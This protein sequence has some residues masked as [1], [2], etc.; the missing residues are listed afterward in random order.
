VSIPRVERSFHA[1]LGLQQ[2]QYRV[3][4]PAPEAAEASVAEVDRRAK[5]ARTR[6]LLAI[7]PETGGDVDGLKGSEQAGKRYLGLGPIQ[8]KRMWGRIKD[9]G[10][11]S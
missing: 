10:R 8:R 9:S 7:V 3:V 11:L 6:A 1:Q 5:T 4:T 2:S